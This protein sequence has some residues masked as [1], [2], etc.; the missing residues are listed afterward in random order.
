MRDSNN[1]E[2]GQSSWL[3]SSKPE[4]ATERERRQNNAILAVVI[5]IVVI[6]S[7]LG[8]VLR[9]IMQTPATIRDPPTGLFRVSAETSTT[10][11]VE[12][13]GFAKTPFPE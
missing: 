3:G 8:F 12:F 7:I 9:E 10:A 2:S 1:R 13:E 11:T 6:I 4:G 5:S